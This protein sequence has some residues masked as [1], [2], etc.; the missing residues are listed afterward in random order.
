VFPAE[1]VTLKVQ[2]KFL[3]NFHGDALSVDV[4]PRA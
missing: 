4:V 3:Q 2:P 1:M